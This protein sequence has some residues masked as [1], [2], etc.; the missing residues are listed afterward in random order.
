MPNISSFG[1]SEADSN[2]F[3]LSYSDFR[4][5]SDKTKGISSNYTTSSGNMEVELDS[6]GDILT[7][8]GTA[9]ILVSIISITL[10]TFV[11]NFYRKTE[12]TVVSLLYTFIAS[13]DILCALGTIYQFGIVGLQLQNKIHLGVKAFDIN[14][15]VFLFLMQVGYRCSVFGNLVLAVSRTITIF[16]PFYQ[17]S[18]NM[19]K[20][21]CVLYAVPL[22]VLCGITV[23]AYSDGLTYYHRKSTYFGY[24]IH[25]GYLIGSGLSF[26]LMDLLSFPRGQDSLRETLMALPDFIALITPVVIIVITC[27]VQIFSIWKASQFATSSNQ[28]HVTITVLLMSTL[29]VICNSPLCVYMAE[30]LNGETGDISSHEKHSIVFG[31]LPPVVNGALNPVI[32]ILRSREMKGKFVNILQRMKFWERTGQDDLELGATN[33]NGTITSS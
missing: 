2:S 7:N 8:T 3:T 25:Y 33:T 16:N 26:L 32:I 10:N 4:G 20:K 27:F 21:A 19:V 30:W 18:K 9:S 23:Y 13:M 29:F 17:I 5:L 6:Y 14:A 1:T 28:R 22:I 12:L 11:I 31:N 15:M 24:T